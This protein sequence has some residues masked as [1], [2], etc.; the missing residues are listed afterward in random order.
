MNRA[1]LKQRAEAKLEGNLFGTKWLH[2][3]LAFLILTV[4][5]AAISGI[6]GLVIPVVGTFVASALKGIITYGIASAFLKQSRTGAAVEVGD[7]FCGFSNKFDDYFLLGLMYN[8]FVWLWSLLFVIPGLI[9]T[10]AWS[11]VYQIKADHP[12]YTW[13]Q[14]LDESNR[15]TMGHKMDIFVLELSF[16]G[17]YIVGGIAL[18][19]GTLWVQTYRQ[20]T[21]TELYESY[22]LAPTYGQPAGQPAENKSQDF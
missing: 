22:K 20:A 14:C 15:M 6:V 12:E 16:I 7:I 10:I 4:I 3:V 18:R 1:E 13:K 21:M 9:K 2:G 5:N 19:V 8:V 17:W 11:F